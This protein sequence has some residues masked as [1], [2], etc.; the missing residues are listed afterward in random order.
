MK[1][2][3]F[4]FEI[5]LFLLLIFTASC[6]AKIAPP[7]STN[8]PA[9]T[10]PSAVIQPT[11][12]STKPAAG[13]K[14]GPDCS[15]IGQTWTSPKDGAV[16]MC[17]P[18][19]EFLMG[20]SETD[21][22]ASADEKPQHKVSLDAFWIDR[23]EVT[24]ASFA[25]CL[26]DG[27]CH[28][29]I[30]D[31]SALTY[32]PYAVHPDFQNYP[33]LIYEADAAADYCQ[34]AGRRLP[35]EAEWEKAARGTDGRIYPW[36]DDLDCSKANYFGCDNA[37]KIDPKGPRCGYS[38]FCRTARVDDFPA[39]ASPYGVLNMAGN[40]WEWV[41]DWY[42]ADYYASSPTDNPG[43]PK[44]GEFKVRRGGGNSSISADL[45][46]TSRASGQGNHYFDGQMGFRCALSGIT[47]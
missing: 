18:A 7:V 42:A 13:A 20:A 35:T 21:P 38:G 5:C 37:S 16:L 1:S 44:D 24:N 47:P 11:S 23:T 2:T 41:G 19:G 26:A 6:S 33:A 22:R 9:S 27:A 40:V 39:G 14:P 8:Q 34:W 25:R 45:R 32:I 17:V 10:A 30:Y 15:K 31:Q 36:G 29:E 43:G 4:S 3:R 46:V 12:Q 28:P